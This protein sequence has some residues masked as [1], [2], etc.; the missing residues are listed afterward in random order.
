[1]IIAQ[2]TDLHV[3]WPEPDPPVWSSVAALRAAVTR[4]LSLPAKVDV[5]LVTGDLTEHGHEEEYRRFAEL[6]EPLDVPVL[7]VPGNHDRRETMREVFRGTRLWPWLG[8]GPRRWC[9]VRNEYPVRLIGLDTSV[10]GEA[11]GE[12]DSECLRWLDAV[13]AE[14]P[15][16][17]T[18][19]FMHHPPFA[20]GIAAMDAIGLRHPEEFA[21]ILSRHPQVFRLLC[22]HVHRPVFGSF[23][24]RS[25]SIGPSPWRSV[26]LTFATDAS[27][28]LVDESPAL[29]MHRWFA[30]AGLVTH[31]CGLDLFGPV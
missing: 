31:H 21:E 25:A 18:L 30:G 26:G 23:A 12:L 8:E 9:L 11:H 6:V 29:H 10:E 19:V 4:V 28:T 22:G 17:P 20:T 27:I 16:R 24:G 1:M 5:V 14:A 15:D 3:S 2:L 13:L 7:V